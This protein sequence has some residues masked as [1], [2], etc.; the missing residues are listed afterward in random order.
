MRLDITMDQVKTKKLYFGY[1]FRFLTS[2]LT[3]RPPNTYIYIFKHCL[4]MAIFKPL[5]VGCRSYE[6]TDFLLH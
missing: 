4:V 3:L 1:F 2:A 5:L 6:L